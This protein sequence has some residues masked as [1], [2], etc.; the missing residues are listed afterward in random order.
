MVLKWIRA[1]STL[2]RSKQAEDFEIILRQTE[3]EFSLQNQTLKQ[4]LNRV[5]LSLNSFICILSELVCFYFFTK[6]NFFNDLFL[7]PNF[8]LNYHFLIY[9]GN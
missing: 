7:L 4:E 8:T 6:F 3:K 9:L 1:L 2:N 5:S